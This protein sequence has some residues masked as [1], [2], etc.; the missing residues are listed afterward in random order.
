MY[1]SILGAMF[2]IA[3]VLVLW[4]CSYVY[5]FEEKTSSKTRIVEILYRQCARWAV[6]S[7]QDEAEVI[8][9]LH[10]NYATGY[11]WALKDIVSTEEFKNITGQDFLA[12][13]SQVVRL[14][15]QAS[16]AIV[17][18]CPDLVR[19]VDPVLLKAIYLSAS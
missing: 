2:I 19:G 6:A 9:L 5:S 10:A 4:L 11:L 12:L 8:R 14:Q 7:Q 17:Q 1:Y 18:K 3:L 15:D 16:Q 13:E